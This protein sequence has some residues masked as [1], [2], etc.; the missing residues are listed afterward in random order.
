M[1]R[2]HAFRKV[3][4]VVIIY[5]KLVLTAIIWGGTFI[6]GKVVV[7]SIEP[8]SA[9]F[10]RFAIA[11]GCL[12]L[13]TKKIEGKL[14]RLKWRQIPLVTILGLSG[15]F[16]YNALFF[17][18]LKA[19][20]ASRAAL[21]IALNPIFI[22]LGSTLFF[23][24]KLTT[25]KLICTILSLVGA[26][27]VISRGNISNLLIGEIGRGEFFIFG[28]VLSW[29]TYTLVGK[30][31]MKELSPLAANTYACMIGGF[32]LFFPALGEGILQNWLQFTPLAWLG[33]L[34]LGLFGSAIGFFWY[35]EGL[36]AIGAAKAGV[37]INLVPV[38]AVLL[39]AFLLNEQLTISLL[40]GGILVVTGV[41]LSNR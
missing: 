31:A 21:I 32:V 40:S 26:D 41:F 22:S 13:I 1:T 17:L 18:G 35:Y 20:P 14:P 12:L 4:H 3:I 27:E 11:S 30:L 23:K 9:A 36:Q 8:F 10:C 37:F 33:V 29:M 15:I 34:Y 28:C 24:E 39:A 7:Q 16:A 19:I 25:L 38:S 2:S 6:A 5:I